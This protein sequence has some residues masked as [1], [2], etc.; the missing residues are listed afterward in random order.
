MKKDKIIAI[1]CIAAGLFLILGS[2][3]GYELGLAVRESFGAFQLAGMLV[4]VFLAVWGTRELI[5]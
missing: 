4:G 5:K 3:F 2:F 1:A